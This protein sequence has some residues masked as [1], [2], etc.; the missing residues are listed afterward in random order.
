MGIFCIPFGFIKIKDYGTEEKEVI[1]KVYGEYFTGIRLLYTILMFINDYLGD[2][3]M[4]Q[5]IDKF[6]VSHAALA[7]TCI[8]LRENYIK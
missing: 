5:I 8:L 6:S 2:I 1:F 7:Y 3:F 4:F